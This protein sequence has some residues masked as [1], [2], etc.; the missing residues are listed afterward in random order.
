MPGQPYITHPIGVALILAS[1]LGFARDAEMM[2]AALLHDAVEDSA[3]DLEDIEPTFGQNHS[4]PRQRRYKSRRIKIQPRCEAHCHLATPVHA[5]Q[6]GPARTHS[7]TGRPHV[8]H[9]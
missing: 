2:A 9:A 6:P 1:E 5:C 4:H 7:Q 8:Q 3:L